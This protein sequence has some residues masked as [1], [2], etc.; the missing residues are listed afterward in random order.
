LARD[1]LTFKRVVKAEKLFKVLCYNEGFVYSVKAG[2]PGYFN[3]KL[4]NPIAQKYI[5]PQFGV[6]CLSGSRVWM[7][8]MIY[9]A[10][11]AGLTIHYSNTDCFVMS[12]GDIVKL[13]ALANDALIGRQLGQ[14]EYEVQASRCFIC[15][16]PKKY[17]HC[18]ANGS[19]RVRFPPKGVPESQYEA[20][21]THLWAR[22]T[23]E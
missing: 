10:V 1:L 6:N 17:L 9:K 8:D 16:S 5:R 11:D 13:N 23:K 3:V 7:Q 12:T 19:V 21:F 20:T 4:I 14:M 18:L 22:V 2:E 15:L